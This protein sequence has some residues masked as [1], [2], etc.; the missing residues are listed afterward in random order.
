MQ[1]SPQQDDA[2]V[3][4]ADWL[5]RD[6]SQLFRL[7]GYAGTGKTTLAKHF[8]EGVDGTVQFAAFTGK[9]AQVMRAKGASNAKTIHSLI[10]RPRGEEEVTDEVTGKTG[11]APTFAL[12]R[13]SDIA[14]A[15]LVIVDEC[16]MV[17]EELGRDLLSFGTPVL[18]LGDPGQLPPISGG[19]FFTDAEPDFLLTEIHRQAAENPIVRLAM[20]VREGREIMH[21]DYGTAQIIGKGDLDT[22]MVTEADQVLVGINRTRRRYNQRLRQLAG[23]DARYPQAGDKLVCLRNDPAKGLLNGS[24][25]KVMTA[26]APGS[27][28]GINLLVSPDDG[29]T[30]RGVAKIKLL[31]AAF[32][33]PDEDVGWQLKRR[34]DDFDYGYALTVHKAQGSQW[35]NVMLFD[36]SFAFRDMRDRWLYTAI[37]RAAERLTIVK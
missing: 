23:F 2:L 11:I 22:A 6:D 30:D 31:K 19:G 14:K 29:D 26:S 8:A 27:K 9:A 24:L 1:F 18:V 17:G 35:D 34:F 20:D 21:G 28:P 3:A 16:S 5:K 7:F 15:K 12:N 37:T 13:Q 10:Y 4:V 32:D 33:N 36:E 25:W